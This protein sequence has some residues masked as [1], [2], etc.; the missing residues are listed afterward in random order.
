[1][2]PLNPHPSQSLTSKE[3]PLPYRPRTTPHL[4]ATAIPSPTTKAEC[5]FTQLQSVLHPSLFDA[6]LAL[7]Y[8]NMTPVQAKAILPLLS[9]SRPDAIVQARTGTGKTLA[10]LLPALHHMLSAGD[11]MTRR[12]VAVLVIA[13]TR[14]LAGQIAVDAKLLLA[15]TQHSVIHAVGGTVRKNEE[16]RIQKPAGSRVIVGTPGRLLEHLSMQPFWRL[17]RQL[18]TLIVDEADHL[19]DLGFKAELEKITALLPSP[20]DRPRQTLLFSATIPPTSRP[21]PPTS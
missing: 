4:P 5:S 7:N 10:Y 8:K 11:A 12:K 9:P 1:M 2:P 21:K 6:V 3:A 19:F 15:Q 16:R 14:E 20:K 17:T 13:P 18:D